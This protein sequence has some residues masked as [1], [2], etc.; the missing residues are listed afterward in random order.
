MAGHNNIAHFGSNGSN[1]S[2]LDTYQDRAFRALT[3]PHCGSIATGAVIAIVVNETPGVRWIRCPGCGNGIVENNGRL[4]PSPKL[5]ENVDG[6][7]AEVAEAYD[8]ARR[9][10]G[11][12]AY[13][14]CELMCRKIL[15]H[16]AVDKG[17]QEGKSF[18]TY[19]DFIKQ[20]GYIT[21]PMQPWADLIRSHGNQSTHR[22]QPASRERA[23][24]TLAFT[25]QLLR[26]VY[27]MDSRARQYTT[28]AA[29]PTPGAQP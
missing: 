29:G 9:T 2:L 19:L 25:T 3:C 16:I 22:L 8:E 23:L 10:A 27:E 7:P 1:V 15:M 14:S 20:S 5:G 17:D 11:I 12:E 21:P 18:V 26:L 28:P 13:T 4:S 24:N 6:L